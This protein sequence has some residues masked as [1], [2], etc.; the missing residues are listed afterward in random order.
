ME[1]AIVRRPEGEAPDWVRDAWIGLRLPTSRPTQTTTVGFG[2]VTGPINTLRQC[3]EQLRG[4]SLRVSGYAVRASTAVNR[5]SAH[6]PEAAQWWRDNASK[7][8]ALNRNLIFNA[9]A[10][11]PCLGPDSANASGTNQ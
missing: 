11:E 10:C 6:H 3:W 4:R 7:L 9:E 5:L 1:I 2:V 8:I